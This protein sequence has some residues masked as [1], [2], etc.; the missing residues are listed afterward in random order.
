MAETNTLICDIVETSI[1]QENVKEIQ[2]KKNY[3][4]KFCE[5]CKRDY[6]DFYQHRKIKHSEKQNK[7]NNLKNDDLSPSLCSGSEFDSFSDLK[8]VSLNEIDIIK[9]IDV[10][11]DNL[12]EIASLIKLKLNSL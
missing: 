4:A 3:K 7:T 9:K 2:K 5:I 12:N 6:K 1:C 8:N 10:A 11:I